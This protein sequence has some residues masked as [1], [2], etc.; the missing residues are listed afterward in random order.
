MNRSQLFA[1][2]FRSEIGGDVYT[3][4]DN[5]SIWIIDLHDYIFSL[6]PY[7]SKGQLVDDELIPPIS[8]YEREQYYPIAVALFEEWSTAQNE[9]IIRD[10]KEKLPWYTLLTEFDGQTCVLFNHKTQEK[11]FLK[12]LFPDVVT[13]SI[14]YVIAITRQLSNLGLTTP[15]YES[16]YL[17]KNGYIISK[18]CPMTVGEAFR[19]N[20]LEKETTLPV[21][22]SIVERIISLEIYHLDAHWDNLL[23]DEDSRI[24][25]MI[26]FDNCRIEPDVDI[27]YRARLLSD[28]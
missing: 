3:D 28:E 26:D 13:E 27:D 21:V 6:V 23:Y 18:Y 7:S 14:S 10:F 2:V 4:R 5:P 15:L 9:K 25:Y 8:L 20:Y 12:I 17:G 22:M 16:G 1:A 11:N 19:K 24:I